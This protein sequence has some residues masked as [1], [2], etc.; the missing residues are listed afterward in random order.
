MNEDQNVDIAY[1]EA[2]LTRLLIRRHNLPPDS[3]QMPTLTLEINAVE[4]LVRSYGMVK[5]LRA[6]A[7]LG[8]GEQMNEDDIRKEIENS[9]E[10]TVEAFKKVAYTLVKGEMERN[11]ALRNVLARIESESTEE[12]IRTLAHDG[13]RNNEANG[14]VI[15][16]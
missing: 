4:N 16:A 10:Q 11:V 3:D 9:G 12:N 15:A 6:C 2:K 1:Y 13:I 7:Q 5:R 8:G 14:N